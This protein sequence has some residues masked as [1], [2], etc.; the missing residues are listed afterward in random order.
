MRWVKERWEPL[1]S[2]YLPALLAIFRFCYSVLIKTRGEMKPLPFVIDAKCTQ[3]RRT[4]FS[5]RPKTTR[6][7]SLAV[8]YLGR[9]DSLLGLLEGKRMETPAGWHCSQLCADRI[10]RRI[11]F[12]STPVSA[13]ARAPFQPES[14]VTRAHLWCVSAQ[15]YCW[16]KS[17]N[18]LIQCV[19]LWPPN[20]LCF[21]TQIS[22]A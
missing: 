11:S 8:T 21:A 14:S 5:S 19:L 18:V 10:R 22:V 3:S 16:P 13:R 17:G 6:S 15:L 12:Y 1:V 7:L 2:G 4:C 9:L 20:Y